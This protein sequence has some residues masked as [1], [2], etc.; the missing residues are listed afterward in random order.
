MRR[1]AVVAIVIGALAGLAGTAGAKVL[2]VGTYKGIRGQYTTIQAA[3]NAARPGDWILIAPGDYK[4]SKIVTPKGYPDF[5]AAVLITKRN[6]HI[7]GMSRSGVIIDGTKPGSSVCSRKGSA[8]N[9]G[10]SGGASGPY[11]SGSSKAPSG[12]NGLMV[13]KAANVSIE[14]LTACNFLGGSRDTG[15][16]IWWN[17]GANSGK[18]G[19]HGFYGAY[20]SAT[21]TYFK[22]MSK[23]GEET[24]ARYGVF[25]S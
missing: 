11:S 24:A 10:L 14:N 21:S 5:P 12:V 1:A 23:A 22:G 19:G 3:V 20:L 8:Q 16:E 17:G 15:N 18:V 7:R 9:F 2:R 25:S 4:T 13:W 6:L